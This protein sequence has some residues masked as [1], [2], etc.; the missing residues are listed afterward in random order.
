[1]ARLGVVGSSDMH[2]LSVL[3]K[4]YRPKSV[5]PYISKPMGTNAESICSSPVAIVKFPFH[6][7]KVLPYF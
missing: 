2:S 3:C 1:M 5:E 6:L 7:Y 4:Y